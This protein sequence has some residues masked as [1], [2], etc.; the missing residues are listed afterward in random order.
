MR[1][2]TISFAAL[3]AGA[4]LEGQGPPSRAIDL[5]GWWTTIFHEDSLERGPGPELADYGGF[6]INEAGRL[7]ALSYSPSRVTLRHH[8]CDG[9]VTAYQV[10]AIG[11]ARAWEERDPHTQRLI[12]VHWYDQ[13]FEGHRTIW[14]DGRPH[15][16]AY[17]PHT[18]MGFSTGTFVGNALMV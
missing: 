1:S 13:T 14:M 8:Q 15:P 7:W 2:I 6:P 11:N 3:L 12:A 5:S 4:T 18:W 17:A 16:P 10:R 9:Y